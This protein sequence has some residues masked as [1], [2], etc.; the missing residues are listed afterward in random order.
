M[1]IYFDK[2]SSKIEFRKIL[3]HWVKF[4]R[5][6]LLNLSNETFMYCLGHI[7]N[8]RW[9]LVLI[10]GE[11]EL[12]IL[13]FPIIYGWFSNLSKRERMACLKLGLESD[14]NM[15]KIEIQFTWRNFSMKTLFLLF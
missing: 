1:E 8:Y 15:K 2:F 14:K 5:L 6:I 12:D 4:T 10:Q 11:M 9:N 13:L 3:F 7:W